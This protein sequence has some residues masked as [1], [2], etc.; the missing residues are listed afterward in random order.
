MK[1]EYE[2]L[3]DKLLKAKKELETFQKKYS[4]KNFQIKI[5]HI[6]ESMEK[7]YRGLIE[8]AIVDKKLLSVELL[9]SQ[10]NK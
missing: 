1:K 7:K 2:I 3:K 5:A 6:T 9:C 4:S 8:K 10:A